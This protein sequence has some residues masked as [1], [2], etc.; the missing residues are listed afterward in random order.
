MDVTLASHLILFLFIF[1]FKYSSGFSKVLLHESK[2]DNCY[3]FFRDLAAHN[4]FVSTDNIVKIGD[5][6]ISFDRW[7]VSFLNLEKSYY[8]R[9]NIV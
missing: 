5:Y 3:F 6:G 7:K 9:I 1:Y 8:I 2:N 4:C